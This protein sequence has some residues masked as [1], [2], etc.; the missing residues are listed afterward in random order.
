MSAQRE[1]RIEPQKAP[2]GVIPGA[3]LGRA[4][5][6]ADYPPLAHRTRLLQFNWKSN[7][8]DPSHVPPTSRT[9]C[10]LGCCVAALVGSA[11][12]ERRPSACH[13]GGA[14]CCY[15][16]CYSVGVASVPVQTC[17]HVRHTTHLRTMS[18]PVLPSCRSPVPRSPPLRSKYP[19]SPHR[20]MTLCMRSWTTASTCSRGTSLFAPILVFDLPAPRPCDA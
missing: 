5:D 3:V 11:V 17:A 13:N 7:G 6:G 15:V 20:I 18:A 8:A 1:K 9:P 16:C 4:P 14:S 19:T 2:S 12:C 10:Y